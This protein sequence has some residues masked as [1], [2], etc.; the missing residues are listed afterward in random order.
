[1][2][3]AKRLID[4]QA[5]APTDSVQ[6]QRPAF[7]VLATAELLRASCPAG[8]FIVSGGEGGIAAAILVA[9]LRADATRRPNSLQANWS[10]PRR[11][12]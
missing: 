3:R 1:M 12:K 11:R 5:V 10:N 4:G 2:R 7:F 9:T 6:H 8:P